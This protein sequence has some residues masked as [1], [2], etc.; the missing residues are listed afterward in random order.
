MEKGLREYLLDEYS[1]KRSVPRGEE[2][3]REMRR[4]EKKTRIGYFFFLKELEGEN[5]KEEKY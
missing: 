4:K 2:R 1:E 3:T 5:G